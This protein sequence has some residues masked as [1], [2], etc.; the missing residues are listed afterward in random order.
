MILNML[1]NRNHRYSSDNSNM[2]WVDSIIKCIGFLLIR[3]IINP[4]IVLSFIIFNDFDFQLLS[5]YC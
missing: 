1:Y 5:M 2:K 3:Y 4:D